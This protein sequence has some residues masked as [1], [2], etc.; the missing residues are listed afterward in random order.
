MITSKKN[1]FIFL[2][3]FP[4]AQAF[5]KEAAPTPSEVIESPYEAC[6]DVIIV[7]KDKYK[8]NEEKWKVW[9]AKCQKVQI[10]EEAGLTRLSSLNE[11]SQYLNLA[12]KVAEKISANLDKSQKYAQCTSSC[13]SG[14]TTCS[15]SSSDTGVAVN[16]EERRAETLKGL[17]LQ[18]RKIR[19]ELA[20]SEVA[21][22]LITLNMRNVLT[23]EDEKRF[24]KDLRDFE[25]ATP[26]PVG[27]TQ[28]QPEEMK[29]AKEMIKRER[30]K[31]ERDYQKM[32]AEK[33]MKDSPELHA[34]WT[35]S[36]VDKQK[37]EHQQKY[38]QLIYEESPVFAVIDSPSKFQNG[39]EPVW[40]DKQVAE[41]F[42][43]LADN[44]K[45]TK[46][47][48]KESMDKGKLE[49][50]RDNGEA[51]GQWLQ[52][53]MPGSRDHNDLL[54]Y[55]GM[56]N[57]VEEVLK[58]DKSL[59]AVASTLSSRRES[60]D[61]QNTG[62]FFVGSFAGGA[63]TKG[64]SKAAVGVFRIGRALSGAESASLSGLAIGSISLGDSFRNY[65]TSVAEATSGV[66]EASDVAAAKSNVAMNLAFAPTLAPAGWGL[67]KV[68][69]GSLGNKMAKDLPEISKLMNKAKTSQAARDEIVD[70]WML[71][72]VKSAIKS[73]VIGSEDE[74]L[75]KS[76]DGRKI[77]NSLADDIQ[78]NN[79][80]F[81]ND[82]K[83][84]DFF[85]KTAATS[86]KHR[87]GDPADLGAKARHLFLSF[88]ADAFQTW[89]PK[90]RIGL[91]KVFN[92]GVEELRTAYVKD[93]A[94]Y[95]K[96]TTDPDSQEKIM[97]SALKRAGVI[98]DT[99]A[100]AMKKCALRK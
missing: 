63:V 77:L 22:P 5:A 99:E 12:F 20:L 36:Q 70:K 1:I 71:A 51:I 89:D 69:Y 90:A 39:A 80:K 59:C 100:E 88:N 37:E 91:M 68:L 19:M 73:K 64:V 85:L 33:K 96:F 94:A 92:E 25:A 30:T 58:E 7:S 28:M 4:A 26:N 82:P 79:P 61:L 17:K 57:Q 27:R 81:F 76:D 8:E 65:N 40:T 3:L 46:A 54:Y 43:K 34:S 45:T 67:G 60:K 86:L 53:L 15:A 6:R 48:I 87:P 18:S 41:A 47:S 24:N 62:V 9:E 2:L 21:S 56:K 52:Q 97:L 35:M 16:C 23:L 55:M 74:T 11:G 13:F 10:A 38:R 32:L 83:N 75:L 95:A 49:F 98:D 84:F 42:V 14:A 50:R 78:K 31:I 93:P 66:K 72:K 29:H 44:A